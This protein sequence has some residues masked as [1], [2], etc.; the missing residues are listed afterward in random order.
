MPPRSRRTGCGWLHDPADAG[1]NEGSVSLS[2]GTPARLP[3]HDVRGQAAAA[4][5]AT[6]SSAGR[7]HGAQE[8]LPPR[9]AADRRHGGHGW[10]VW[11]N[12]CLVRALQPRHLSL[13]PV[14]RTWAPTLA[15][16]LR[17]APSTPP[18]TAPHP[19]RGPRADDCACSVLEAPTNRRKRRQEPEA[20]NPAISSQRLLMVVI[21]CHLHTPSSGVQ[22]P[23]GVE[24]RHGRGEGGR[25]RRVKL[26]RLRDAHSSSGRLRSGHA[27]AWKRTHSPGVESSLLGPACRRPAGEAREREVAR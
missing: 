25:R 1:G 26:L 14:W 8:G 10:L 3:R 13:R 21:R 9:P 4:D 5:C 15:A 2:P 17:T 22:L 12:R 18:S 27:T 6:R 20:W 11:P 16:C 19:R 23:V 7:L 24:L